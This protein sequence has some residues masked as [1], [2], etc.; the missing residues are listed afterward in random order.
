MPTYANSSWEKLNPV[1]TSDEHVGDG[2]G[3][4][5]GFTLGMAVGMSVGVALGRNVGASVGSHVGESRPDKT[6]N[7]PNPETEISQFS[8]QK[9]R[10]SPGQWQRTPASFAKVGPIA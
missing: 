10:L 2:V 8:W 4:G 1:M 6:G 5:V 9:S 3:D 7:Q